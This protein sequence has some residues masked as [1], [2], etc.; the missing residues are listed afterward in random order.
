MKR[1]IKIT[2]AIFVL[3]LIFFVGTF[4]YRQ[5]RANQVLIPQHT[6]ALIKI[7]VDQLYKS[8]A[9]NFIAHPW[10]YLK[11]EKQEK[12]TKRNRDFDPGLKM[13]SALYLYAINTETNASFYSRFKLNNQ[14]KLIQFLK[15]ELHFKIIKLSPTHYLATSP[16]R[17]VSV[18][19]NDGE[20]AIALSLKPDMNVSYLQDILKGKNFIPLAESQFKEIRSETDHLIYSDQN[21]RAKLNFNTGFVEFSQEFKSGAIIPARAPFHRKFNT[22]NTLTMWLCADLKNTSGKMYGQSKL[23]LA[24]DSLAKYFKGYID[25]EWTNS[26]PVTDTIITYQY[27]DDF[28]KVEKI[29][30]QK[31]NIPNLT[32]N[33][34][35]DAAGLKSYL[36]KQNFIQPDSSVVNKSVFPLYKL[37]VGSSK[38]QLQLTTGKTQSV[39]YTKVPGDLFFYLNLNFLELNKQMEISLLAPYIKPFKQLEIKGTTIGPAKIRLDG[40]LKLLNPDIN[41]LYQ[42]L[43]G[44]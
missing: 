18:L 41:S 23:Q 33:I 13:P 26:I 20:V 44:F 27:N 15:G 1:F 14:K 35:S 38:D 19:F 11:P 3:L 9:A 42:I 37:R 5:Y 24:S 29:S 4:K 7:N 2:A 30:L 17:Q 10:Y 31:R 21:H 36:A 22:R 25:M 34:N 43:S 32:L 6:T 12:T 8:L 16:S 39:N 28:E 40:A